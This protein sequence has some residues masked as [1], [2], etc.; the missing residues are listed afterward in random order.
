[1]KYKL[2]LTSLLFT[3]GLSSAQA[4]NQT[5]ASVQ[6]LQHEWAMINY[7]VK[8][9][10]PQLAKF[11]VLADKAQKLSQAS[12]NSAELKIWQAIILS[13]EA[14]V[15]GGMGALSLVKKAR[16]LLLE[17]QKINP[18]ALNG[19]AYTSLGSLYY[20]V[21]GWPIG[22][23]NDNRAESNLKK[24]LAIN[25]KGIDPNYFYADFLLDQDKP[26]EAIAVL[27]MA[28]AAP[29][30]VNRPIADAGR[31]VEV[32]QLMRKAQAEL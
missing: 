32:Q 6:T 30:R 16:N 20:Q 23:G 25:P 5:N 12:P 2:L 29:N 4:D 24:A 22:F 8:G 17:S 1:M 28:L 11:Q 19:S 9:K 10:K 15:K 13:T 18:N 7:K 27:K 21:P 3:V 31:R 26:A 14:G